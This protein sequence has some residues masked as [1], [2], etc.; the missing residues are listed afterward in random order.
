MF[1]RI[2]CI[3]LLFVFLSGNTGITQRDMGPGDFCRTQETYVE[4]YYNF[5]GFLPL[6]DCYNGDCDDPVTRD[7]WI[8][9]PSDPIRYIRIY[10]H[11]FREDDGS[12]PATTEAN[13]TAQVEALNVAYLPWKIQFVHSMRFINSSQYRS[14]SGSGEIYDMKNLYAI[15]PDLQL[16]IYVT[17]YHGASFGT[18]PWDEVRSPLGNQGGVVLDET[19][20]YPYFSDV[21]THEIGHCI[22][23]WH[24]HHGVSEVDQCG[25]CWE[26]A[27]GVNGDTTGDLCSDTAPTPT[28]RYCTDPGGIDPCS[29]V[30]WGDTD[31]ENYMSYAG[32]P[33]WI[34][35][36]EQ[37]SGRLHCWFNDILTSWEAETGHSISPTSFNVHGDYRGDVV[38][39]T[40]TISN[41]DDE[42]LTFNFTSFP[43]WLSFEPLSGSIPAFDEREITVG[44]DPINY[45]VGTVL[46][47]DAHLNTSDPV[48][49]LDIIPCTFTILDPNQGPP[50]IV[51][52][53]SPIL[54]KKYQYDPVSTILERRL[55]NDGGDRLFYQFSDD[56]PWINASEQ[57]LLRGGQY[58]NVRMRFYSEDLGWGIY[59]G[60][61]FVE[62]NDPAVENPLVIDVTLNVI[63]RTPTKRGVDGIPDNFG[64]S[65]N[66]PNPANP[67]TAIKFG[68][69]S[70]SNV[71]LEVFDIIGRRIAVLIDRP[72][73]A[74]YHEITWD[75]KNSAGGKV[76]SGIY[77]YKLETDEF[78]SVK[79]MLMLK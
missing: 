38:Y 79:K 53:T 44:F 15:D 78:V 55:T 26:R 31:P 17:D 6:H 11:V 48:Q 16:N 56:R 58:R 43:R 30:P 24:T 8:P 63:I 72:M 75:G 42:S 3:A 13:V 25:E 70:S 21:A 59:T 51:F 77:L 5:Y 9:G 22:G 19:H 47:A 12:N 69:P 49:P 41:L 7:S 61:I 37:Q 1:I 57:G 35:F 62:H 28:N 60:H 40:L 73:N 29:S 32:D 54:V 4:E 71:R 14:L 10:F 67:S 45:A 20:F 27:D 68:L 65:Q 18:F 76:A 66:Y 46:T 33:C 36:T 2:I 74:G 34:E 52:D 64:L 39:R 23:L 50:S